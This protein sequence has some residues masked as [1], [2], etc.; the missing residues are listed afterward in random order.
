MGLW[1]H[2]GGCDTIFYERS[3]PCHYHAPWRILFIAEKGVEYLSFSAK[4]LICGYSIRFLTNQLN[5]DTC[6]NIH[7]SGQVL[8]RFCPKFK[9]VVDME[10]KMGA[11]Q[12]MV[13]RLCMTQ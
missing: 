12:A 8:D 7:Y 3:Q 6:F 9:L 2:N 13:Q 10:E 11:M 1:R 5:C 4:F